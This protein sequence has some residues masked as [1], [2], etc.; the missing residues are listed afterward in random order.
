MPSS[1]TN[2]DTLITNF[3]SVNSTDKPQ[4]LNRYSGGHNRLNQPYISGYW[5][6][7][8]TPPHGLM[9]NSTMTRNAT[10]WFH[11]TAESFTPPT[12]TITKADVPGMG[13]VASS[14]AAGQELSRTFTVA[15]REYQGL[16]IMNLLQMWTSMIDSRSGMSSLPSYVPSNYKGSA[17]AALCK[18]TASSSNGTVIGVSDIEQLFYFEGVFPETLPYDTLTSDIATN[19]SA[20]LSVTFSFDGWPMTKEHP[21]LIKEF[22]LQM[23]ASSADPAVLQGKMNEV[24]PAPIT[25]ATAFP[26]A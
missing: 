15:F 16:P 21:T 5:Y 10:D 19:D 17:Y 8:M 25:I 6:L 18:P 22:L 1:L 2:L 24:N 13:G 26:I 7:I 23:S 12:K 20:Q 3:S 14:F 4:V 9:N 11:A